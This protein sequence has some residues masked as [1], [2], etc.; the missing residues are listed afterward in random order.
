MDDVS[1]G[2]AGGLDIAALEQGFEEQYGK[3]LGEDNPNELQRQALDYMDD[4]YK[5]MR[6]YIQQRREIA[7]Q[8]ERELQN[9]LRAL[10]AEGYSQSQIN[11]IFSEHMTDELKKE[12]ISKGEELA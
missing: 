12:L 8:C 2:T 7:E 5:H 9:I 3:G 6:G 10:R 1:S 4:Q 11:T